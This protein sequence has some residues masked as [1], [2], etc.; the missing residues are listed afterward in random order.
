MRN[1]GRVHPRVESIHL[2]HCSTA[3][4]PFV[5]QDDDH[6]RFR[7]GKRQNARNVFR[8]RSVKPPPPPDC[9][10]WL[11]SASSGPAITSHPIVSKWRA[12]PIQRL[13]GVT[14]MF[15][16]VSMDSVECRYD[17]AQW[18]PRQ[19]SMS[20][21]AT[22]AFHAPCHGAPLAHADPDLVTHTPKPDV[23]CCQHTSAGGRTKERLV[24][25]KLQRCH[26]R[27]SSASQCFRR[28]VFS[29]MSRRRKARGTRASS[30]TAASPPPNDRSPE[31]DESAAHLRC[32]RLPG[33]ARLPPTRIRG[34]TRWV[35]AMRSVCAGSTKDLGRFSD[36][37]V[38]SKQ[39]PMVQ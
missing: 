11:L 23:T 25:P 20:T 12:D 3:P 18:A 17:A 37:Q 2:F 30:I 5:Q 32:R 6:A 22:L 21:D 4:H 19:A 8:K 16:R 39:L 15:A 33:S 27:A 7:R 36:V 24:A 10:T 29:P 9:C 31:G 14:S 28:R 38:V 35:S 1:R 34:R 13:A 26:A